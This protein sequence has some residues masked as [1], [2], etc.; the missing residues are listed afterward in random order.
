M[1][2]KG[3]TVIQWAGD[4]STEDRLARDL[5]LSSLQKVID[6]AIEVHGE[7]NVREALR[8]NLGAELPT[9]ECTIQ[10]WINAEIPEDDARKAIG[11]TAKQ[12]GWFKQIHSG[13]RLGE[14]V[15]SALSEISTTDLAV[16]LAEL[17]KWSYDNG[18]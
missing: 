4:A 16:K 1:R 6:L 9:G 13:E 3:V 2:R 12:R 7:P 18:G 15:A 14:V 11:T 5:P 10:G 8:A 17:E